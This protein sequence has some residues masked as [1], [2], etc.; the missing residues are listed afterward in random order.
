MPKNLLA[1]IAVLSAMLSPA[2]LHAAD[3]NSGRQLYNQHCAACHG[4]AGVSTM[5][6]APHVARGGTLMQPDVMLVE[7]IRRGRNAMPAYAGVLKDQ[8]ILDV[9]AYMRTFRP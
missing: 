4:P 3:V 7:S 5:P 6:N 8:Q 9:I 1:R 2:A